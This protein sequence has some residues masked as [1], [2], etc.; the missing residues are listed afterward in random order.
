LK[1]SDLLP[2][3]VPVWEGSDAYVCP[4]CGWLFSLNAQNRARCPFCR[5]P[6]RRAVVWDAPMGVTWEPTPEETALLATGEVIVYGHDRVW[7][8]VRCDALPKE[9]AAYQRQVERQE[10]AKMAQ[11]ALRKSAPRGVKISRALARSRG[12]L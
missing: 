1:R 8:V 12:L 5:M 9:L 7:G 11:D 4:S 2:V 3:A 10:A 6:Y